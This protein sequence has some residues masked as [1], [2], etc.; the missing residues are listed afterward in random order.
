M[1]LLP[2]DPCHIPVS[3]NFGLFERKLL[4]AD[5]QFFVTDSLYPHLH[6]TVFPNR[7]LAWPFFADVGKMESQSG[8]KKGG[9]ENGD[10]TD[11]RE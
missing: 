7:L 9:A 8:L 5:T 3:A 10:T 11:F 2:V 6:N 1:E 4:L